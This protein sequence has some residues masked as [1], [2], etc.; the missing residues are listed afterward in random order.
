M[1]NIRR[2]KTRK[3][4]KQTG[5]EL[6]IASVYIVDLLP[7]SS[8]EDTYKRDKNFFDKVGFF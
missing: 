7:I 8:L 4:R 1:K 5:G 6:P 2:K 3:N